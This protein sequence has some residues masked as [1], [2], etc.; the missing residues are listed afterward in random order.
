MV[1]T[2]LLLGGSLAVAQDA[3][4]PMP[5][6]ADRMPSALPEIPAAATVGDTAALTAPPPLVVPEPTTA[7]EALA[8][9]AVE[10]QRVTLSAQITENGMNIPE[11]LVWRVF[12]TRTD[13]SGELALAAKSEDAQARFDLAPGST[14]STLPTAARRRAKRI[15]VSEGGTKQI[16]RAR[17]GCDC[18]STRP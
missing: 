6:P 13:T 15:D 16:H 14:S 8:A 4:V 10:K 3:P 17:C 2:V 18:G 11:G 9:V 5:R 12:D 1:A 7:T